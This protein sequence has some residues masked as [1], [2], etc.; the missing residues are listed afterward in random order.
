M[1]FRSYS[2]KFSW[3]SLT[4]NS[5]HPGNVGIIHTNLSVKSSIEHCVQLLKSRLHHVVD[6]GSEY[7]ECGGDP[8]ESWPTILID[9]HEDTHFS[10][11]KE[12]LDYIV[13]EL[14]K[15]V[16]IFLGT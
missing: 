12:H 2:S 5:H 16:S 3:N 11:I 7:V 1:L 10:Y 9:G 6:L 4:T 8:T 15:N 13:F 14:L